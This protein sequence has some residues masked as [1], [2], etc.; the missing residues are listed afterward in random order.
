V[1]SWSFAKTLKGQ[2]DSFLIQEMCKLETGRECKLKKGME[3]V[4]ENTE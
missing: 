3:S 2:G 4:L 1:W